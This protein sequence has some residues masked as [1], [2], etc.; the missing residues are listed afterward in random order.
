VA[1]ELLADRPTAPTA[2]ALAARAVDPIL[3]GLDLVIASF[4]LALTLPLLLGVAL[5]TLVTS[6]R[7]VLYRGLRVGRGGRTFT[8]LKLRTLAPDAES[9]LGP[10]RGAELDRRTDGEVTRLGQWLR[11]SQ[12]DELPQLLNVL[13]GDMS[14]VG[15][16]PVRPALL[17]ELTRD[18]PNYWQRL[19]VRPGLT[20]FAQTRIERQLSWQEK[21]AHDLEYVADRSVG[22]YLHVVATTAGRV[23]RQSLREVGALMAARFAHAPHR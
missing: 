2:E 16:R 12:L 1:R 13:R 6:G 18:I 10:Y 21:L 23:A 5:A 4:A 15:P 7:P 22:L 14:L 20:G 9:R 17:D 3:R 11:A 8:M 19:V